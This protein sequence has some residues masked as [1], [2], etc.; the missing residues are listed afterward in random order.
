MECPRCFDQETYGMGVN[1]VIK[2]QHLE[3]DYVAYD[4]DYSY[5]QCKRCGKI[6]KQQNGFFLSGIIEDVS[7][8]EAREL[9]KK[10]SKG[11]GLFGTLFLIG[12]GFVFLSSLN[13]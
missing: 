6:R 3:M 1:R 10:S 8:G 7:P 13:E 2:K 11:M 5:Y 9:I 12:A 4:D